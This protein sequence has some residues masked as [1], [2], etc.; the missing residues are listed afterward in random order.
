[1][2][3]NVGLHSYPVSQVPIAD[4]LLRLSI[5]AAVFHIFTLIHSYRAGP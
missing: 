3:K 1:M 4:F 2:E 5:R